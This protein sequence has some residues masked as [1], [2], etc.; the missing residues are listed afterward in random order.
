MTMLPV[1]N[2]QVR[3]WFDS[4]GSTLTGPS[5]FRMMI[6]FAQD[7]VRSLEALMPQYRE[8]APDVAS[9]CDAEI[10]AAKALITRMQARIAQL[11]NPTS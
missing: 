3:P 11:E 10:A 1:V 6:L 8:H 9:E 7:D 2:N 4:Y 5:S